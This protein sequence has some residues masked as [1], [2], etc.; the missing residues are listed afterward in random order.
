LQLESLEDRALPSIVF[1]PHFGVETIAPGSTND[2]QQHPTVDFVFS[3][4]YWS[5]AQGQQDETD[6]VNLAQ[7][8]LSGPYLSGLKQ[9][10]SDG[11]AN[12][13]QNWSD[14]ATLPSQP[15]TSTLQGF[16][17]N[18][19]SSHGAFPGIND[20]QH[21]PIYVVVS[22]PT[23]SA[24]YNGG[25]N[26]Q[27]T[28]YLLGLI[29]EN[30]HMVWLGT[31]TNQWAGVS[32]DT[33]VW[34]DAYTLTLSHELAETI[35]DPDSNGIRVNPPS[36]LPA[37]LYGGTQIGDN[38]PEPSGGIHYGY[39]LNGAWVQ[40][41]WS[42]QDQAFIVPDGNAQN[43]YLDPVWNGTSFTGTYNLRIVGDQLG[44]NYADDIGVGPTGVTSNVSVTQN[45]EF[46]IFDAG[47]INKID[48]NTG[49]GANTVR[50]TALP[51]GVTLNIDS[52]GQS[53]DQVTI[54]SDFTSLALIQGAVNVSNTSGQT[55]LTVDGLDSGA[56]NVKVTDHSV[57]F[58]QMP[59]S[60]TYEGGTKWNDGSLHG[61]T[62]LDI[63][64]GKGNNTVDVESTPALSNVSL[65]ADTGD[66]ISGPAAGKVTVLRNHT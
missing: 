6:L 53:T 14:A 4:N 38:E 60:I 56:G 24:Q 25:Y 32:N 19:I 47:A 34:K 64:D 10:G 46:A 22:D 42:N 36:G 21:A 17:Q 15:S 49:G 16:L 27:G 45:G 35:S 39:R 12:F 11:T 61:V 29:P 18:S 8:I 44:V 13:G 50:V 33:K 1:T 57:A 48:I 9:Y 40:P 20:W 37:S 2:G 55:T 43:F 5:T 3:G 58:S 65:Y 59:G 28:Y 52:F 51:Q 66:T 30:I 54:G 63:I 26:A 41:Y 23:S 31:S 7:S 62:N